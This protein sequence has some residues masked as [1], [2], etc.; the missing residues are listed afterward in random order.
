MK[1]IKFLDL[2]YQYEMLKEDIDSAINDVISNSAFIGGE[3]STRF[4]N[5]FADFQNAEHCIGVANG[6]DAIEIAIEAL[7]LPKGSEII[8][9]ANSF[10]ASSEAVTRL[11]HKVVFCDCNPDNYTIS[12]PS[13]KAKITQNTKAIVAVHLYGHP[14]DMEALLKIANEHSLKI[15]EDCAQAHGAEFKGKRIGALGDIGAFS[16]YPGK[17]L[18]AYGDAGAIVTNDSDLAVKAKMISNHGRIDKYNHVFEGRNSRLDNLQAAILNV[19]LKSLEEWTKRRIEIADYYM[20]N[21]KDL[22]EIVLPKRE[23]WARQVYHLF[24]IRSER[25]DV[26]QKFLEQQGIQTGIHYPIALPKLKAYEYLGHGHRDFIACQ[27]DT[28]LLSL[29][30]GEHLTLN[31]AEKVVHAIKSFFNNP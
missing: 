11:G 26:L 23:T 4:L 1:I 20:E 6:T 19:K 16:F 24:V 29:P 28:K 30:I 17:N 31:D 3:E 2:K 25:R 12:I 22:D 8:V 21:L 14:C 9:P 5:D 18:G 13:L 15:I 10:I 7:E 27:L